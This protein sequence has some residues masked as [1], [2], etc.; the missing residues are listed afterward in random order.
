MPWY[1]SI[2][3]GFV[4]IGVGIV[5]W[6]NSHTIEKRYETKSQHFVNERGVVVQHN[7]SPEVFK[8]YRIIK[9]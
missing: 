5:S 3:L 1:I 4:F 2:I 7:V 8:E 6:L 9:K